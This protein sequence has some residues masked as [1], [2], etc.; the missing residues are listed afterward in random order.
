MK[1][2]L[3]ALD[4]SDNY[5]PV[6]TKGYELAVALKASLVLL[7]VFPDTITTS[8]DSFS[9]LY[10]TV[11]PLNLEADLQLVEKLKEQSENF[12]R[13]V[14]SELN[15][16]SAEIYTSEGDAARAIIEIANS[17]NADIIVM[18]TH[19]RSRVDSILMGNVTK[20]V[21]RDTHLPLFIIP[22]K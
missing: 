16:D 14:K 21:L 1:K 13:N 22:V 7:H 9:S 3:I 15:A 12:L 19:S 20:Q 6:S 10:P 11:G 8:L 5:H 4:N 18:G 17:C 2:V